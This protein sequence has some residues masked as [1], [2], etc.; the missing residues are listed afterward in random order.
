V[1]GGLAR[2]EGHAGMGAELDGRMGDAAR[3][4]GFTLWL[5]RQ[6]DRWGKTLESLRP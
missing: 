5:S 3:S 6:R 4:Y 2:R 1:F